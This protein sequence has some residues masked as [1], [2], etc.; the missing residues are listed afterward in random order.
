M[1]VGDLVTLSAAGSKQDQNNMF[2]YAKYGMVVKIEGN[3]CKPLYKID[4]FMS[5]KYEIFGR[6]TPLGRCRNGNHWRYEIKKL[7]KSKKNT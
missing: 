4:W 3:D 7:K 6:P 2:V 1:K 5:K